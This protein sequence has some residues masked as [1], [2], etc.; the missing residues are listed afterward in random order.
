MYNLDSLFADILQKRGALVKWGKAD[1]G[2]YLKVWD[3]F[4]R[5]LTTTLEKRQTLSVPN[6]CK[7][8]W[9]VEQS[10]DKIRLRP[11]F[12]LADSLAKIVGLTAKSHPPA[13]EKNLTHTEEFNFSKAAIRYAQDLTKDNVFMG[14][15]A[16]VNQ[17]GEACS[18]GQEVCIDFEVGR[19][20]CR[21][22]DVTFSFVSDVYS[23]EGLDVP[24]SAVDTTDY[25][26][27]VTFSAPSKDAL[28]LRV[29][30]SARGETSPVV[31][32]GQGL[33]G[34]SC[35]ADGH[36]GW[37]DP[38]PVVTFQEPGSDGKS[39]TGDATR[40][41]A[42]ELASPVSDEVGR[43]W[44][45][46][47][48]LDRYI[49]ALE[50]NAAEAICEKERFEGHLRYAAEVEQNDLD[51]RRRIAKENSD[52]LR[53]QMKQAEEKRALCRA[54]SITQASD[55]VFP[56]FKEN[57]DADV[58]EYLNVR[59]NNLK[60]DLDQQVEANERKKGNRKRLE[61]ELENNNLEAT[62]HELAKL[63]VEEEQ[64][65]ATE[66]T[67]L[68]QAWSSD[69]KLKKV[70]KAIEGHHKMPVKKSEL[71]ELASGLN[72]TVPAVPAVL[73]LPTFQGPAFGSTTESPRGAG[74]PPSPRPITGSARSSGRRMPLSAAGSLALQKERLSSALSRG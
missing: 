34:S 36:G 51:W 17:F 61:R 41:K 29:Q 67:V 22:H 33:S 73:P 38:G 6:F 26:P 50:A 27:S 23:W 13:S 3:A 9:R 4:N 10:R 59:R 53:A 11:H 70:A 74:V 64:R 60:Q 68:K 5:Y 58:R 66:L 30:G 45:Q 48:A 72:G 24:A 32:P 57:P 15:R 16:I 35:K 7:I 39:E 20:S 19:L 71:L 69:L 2:D 12:Q 49:S 14:L 54:Q 65:K 1:K 40:P 28:T 21:E 62:Y 31:N 18:S 52:H 42:L 44:A 43:Q 37:H 25:K 56:D 8:G 47:E 46:E 55:H 63:R